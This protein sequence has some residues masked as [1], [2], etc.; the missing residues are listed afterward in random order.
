MKK[1]HHA[2]HD[3]VDMYFKSLSKIRK[4]LSGFDYEFRNRYPLIDMR[5]YYFKYKC[6]NMSQI[7]GLFFNKSRSDVDYCKPVKIYGDCFKNEEIQAFLFK[8]GKN[9]YY[10]IFNTNKNIPRF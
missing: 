8:D 1:K 3:Q 6:D 5:Q 9:Y 10:G 7:I 4:Y 2:I